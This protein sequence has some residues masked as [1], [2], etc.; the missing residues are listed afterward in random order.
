MVSNAVPAQNLETKHRV[1]ATRCGPVGLELT[2]DRLET[3]HDQQWDRVTI[4]L[5]NYISRE[6]GRAWNEK[7]LGPDRDNVGSHVGSAHDLEI[8]CRGLL[9]SL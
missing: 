4:F 5:V 1:R 7:E 6:I 8:L 9:E 2:T 3:V